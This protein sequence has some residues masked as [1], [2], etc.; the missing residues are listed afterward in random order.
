[1]KNFHETVSSLDGCRVFFAFLDSHIYAI[2]LYSLF[3]SLVVFFFRGNVIYIS[4]NIRIQN[5]KR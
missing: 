3:L 4:H 2:N 1:M 5:V